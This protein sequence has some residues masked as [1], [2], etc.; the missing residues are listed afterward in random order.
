MN[1]LFC[2][3]YREST[4][5]SD[6][7]TEWHGA[8]IDHVL[9]LTASRAGSKWL[10]L[11]VPDACISE[12]TIMASSQSLDQSSNAPK[13]ST[14]T[15]RP[16]FSPGYSLPSSW[17]LSSQTL[18]RFECGFNYATCYHRRGSFVQ[19]VAIGLKCVCVRARRR[20]SI[21]CYSSLE[22]RC[23]DITP[24]DHKPR[25]FG[26]TETLAR[27]A[28]IYCELAFERSVDMCACNRCHF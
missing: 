15:S 4:E 17:I 24:I 14:Y 7:K 10:L 8:T 2:L 19:C 25:Q 28:C 1:V 23:P 27:N 26:R 18:E 20:L 9:L 6:I 21:F 16:I 11:F 12:Y 22:L 13:L 5:I 3:Y